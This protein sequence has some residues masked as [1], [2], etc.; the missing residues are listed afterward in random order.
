MTEIAQAR[1]GTTPAAPA[2]PEWMQRIEDTLKPFQ[3]TVRQFLLG[4]PAAAV[5]ASVGSGKTLITLSALSYIRPTGHILVV[6]PRNIAV[7]VW[8]Q[9]VIDWDIPCGSSRSTS[10]HPGCSTNAASPSRPA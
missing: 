1:R 3:K 2:L 9:E 7:D 4:R 5:W 8:P 10:P 6:A